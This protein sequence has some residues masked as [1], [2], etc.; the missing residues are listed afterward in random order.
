M[1]YAVSDL[2]DDLRAPRSRDELIAAGSRLYD[3]LADY[4]LRYQGRWSA[5]GKAIPRTL[6]QAD[7]S[8]GSAYCDAFG[9]LLARGEPDA[10]IRLADDLLRGSG[11]SLFEGY[12]SDA[13]PGWRRPPGEGV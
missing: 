12:R 7:P 10:V 1:R 11:G 13:P 8:F 3:Q 4:Y 9:A 6:R 5:K 2:V